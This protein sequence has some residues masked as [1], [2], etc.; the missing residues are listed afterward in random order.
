MASLPPLPRGYS[1][2]DDDAPAMPSAPVVASPRPPAGMFAAGGPPRRNTVPRPSPVADGRAAALSVYPGLHITDNRRDPNSALGRAN[3]RSW[4]V[5]SAGAI[6]SRPLPGMTF[7]DY[8]DGYRRAGFDIIESRDEVSNPSGHATGPH[9][10][11]V[12]GGGPPP[13]P[14]G[15]SFAED[16]EVPPMPSVP[17]RP[18]IDPS[19]PP[20]WGGSRE[21]LEDRAARTRAIAARI[22]R[23]QPPTITTSMMP[24][25]NEANFNDGR[26]VADVPD[27]QQMASILGQ[28]EAATDRGASEGELV[29]LAQRL[30][31]LTPEMRERIA[32]HVR[33]R[34]EDPDRVRPF[35]VFVPANVREAP[36]RPRDEL[37]PPGPDATPEEVQ[38]WNMARIAR[39]NERSG[40]SLRSHEPGLTERAGDLLGG[41]LQPVMGRYAATE[42]GNNA[43]DLLW[44]TG[45]GAAEDLQNYD[46]AQRRAMIEGRPL[47]MA[48]NQLGAQVSAAGLIPI[49]GPGT[50][51]F[52]QGVRSLGSRV[53]GMFGRGRAAEEL[54][55][56]ASPLA[57]AATG[58]GDEAPPVAAGMFANAG[59][60]ATPNIPARVPD[61]IDIGS[62]PPLPPGYSFADEPRIGR[63]APLGEQPSPAEMADVARR[64]RPDDVLPIPANRIE[65]YDEAMRANPGTIRD[66]EAA[67]PE[68]FLDMRTL[69][70]PRDSQRSIRH[71]GPLDAV[72]YLRYNGGVRD[73]GGELR[74]LGLNNAP[75]DGTGDRQLGALIRKDGMTLDEA[76]EMLWGAGYFRERPDVNEVLD[77][78]ADSQHGRR[79]W[80]PGDMDEVARYEAALDDWNA[81][82]RARDEGAPAA[83]RVGARIGRDD[84]DALDPPAT[85][86]E[87]LPRAGGRVANINLA[88]IETSRDI[89]RLLRNVEDRF[90][91]FDAARRGEITHAET[92]ALADEL[93]MTADDLLQ[94]RQGQALNA[95]Q[96]L[97]ARQLLAKSSDEVLRLADK[98]TGPEAS[99]V[100]RAQ[101]SEALLRHAAIHEQVS[102]AVTEAGRALSALRIAAKS[103]A[104][105]GRIH[106]AAIEGAGGQRKLEDIAE[107]I[108]NLQRQG[109]TAGGVNRFA[110]DALKPSLSDKL[111]E[112]WYNSLLSGPQTHAVNI[113]SNMLTA[114]LQL[115]EQAAAAGIGM[116]RRGVRA[117]MGKED[118]FNRVMFSELGP[119]V[120]GLMQGAREGAR[121]A[122]RTFITGDVADY[123]TK[124]ES[125]SQRAISGWKGS[126]IRTPSRG[127]AAE[128]EFFKGIARRMEIAG[129][130]TRKARSEGLRGQA[131][132][133]RIDD[134]TRN[135]TDEMLERALDYGRYLTFQ[136]PMKG[137]PQSLSN[138]TQ[139]Q[140]WLKLFLPF[141]RTPTNI[142]KFAIERSPMAPILR[143][144]RDNLRA[145]GERQA[146]AVARMALGTGLGLTVAQLAADGTITGGGPA[147]RRALSLM[148][149]QGWQ[150]YSIRVGDQYYSYQRLDPLALTLGTAADM[151]GLQE[152]MTPAQADRAV[153]LVLTSIISNLSDKTWLSGV[154]DVISAID[155]PD[156]NLGRF[157]RRLGGS[158]AVPT[159]VAQI[160]RTI[161]PVQREARTVLD[162]VRARIPGLSQTLMPR[163]DVWGDEIVNEGGL[164]PDIASPIWSSTRRDDPVTDELLRLGQNIGRPSRRAAGGDYTPWEYDRYQA[165]AGRYTRGDLEEAMRDPSWQEM[166]DDDRRATVRR[167]V[168]RARRDARA[169]INT[170][171]PDGDWDALPVSAPPLP[172]GVSFID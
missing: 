100:V 121:A 92:R 74:H 18:L 151:V 43:R 37:P 161:D 79:L 53:R 144:V 140:P 164:G 98:A 71:R 25:G 145:G 159:G 27:P 90:G 103:R 132:R 134:L 41:A 94:R 101:F 49:I 15:Y 126:V 149:A 82:T 138:W 88:N 76:G 96:A 17:S 39:A 46:E 48:G 116:L 115:P 155:D 170:P 28:L 156:R 106:Q 7:D 4:H 93:G 130:A 75:R 58:A 65:D 69:P 168:T 81:V 124:V 59:R 70:H 110:V 10:H 148:R 78:L 77:V 60:A 83:E 36:A 68:T 50:R 95:E 6:D 97:A 125:R 29:A 85:A 143:E 120:V 141:I 61:R 112:L 32:T 35:N 33:E 131:L 22:P 146:L 147:D 24:A 139:R 171:G 55:S 44:W 114:G 47:D 63:V 56:G 137:F 16:G 169:D 113:L 67:R 45:L 104:V 123:V 13:L 157:V 128:D 135:P 166:E 122:G 11:V 118:D 42:A 26:Y 14:E 111:V 73:Q 108:L 109:V 163:R 153:A 87:D 20:D 133:D 129:L 152:H 136:R 84:L 30:N 154:S 91:G 64:V 12:L 158:I 66:Y 80:H 150:P 99:D 127:L 3:P 9:W 21:L 162:A 102:G 57:M 86:Y 72:A 160:A 23:P 8:L 19:S 1:F 40:A 105:S 172:P 34:D 2:A 62:P 142:F 5:A 54:E 119:R 38:A 89:S 117:A 167:I 52:G 31:V 51:R 107:G 165:L